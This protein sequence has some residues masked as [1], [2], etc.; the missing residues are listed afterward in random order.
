VARGRTHDGEQDDG[1]P[2]KA[3]FQHVLAIRFGG[4]PSHYKVT[5]DAERVTLQ[6][7]TS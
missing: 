6:T 4:N 1:G 7:T 2:E 3:L 5:D